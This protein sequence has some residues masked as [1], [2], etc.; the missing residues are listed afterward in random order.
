MLV[1]VEPPPYESPGSRKSVSK[2]P[3]PPRAPLEQHNALFNPRRQNI[4]S[5]ADIGVTLPQQATELAAIPHER[6]KQAF[7]LSPACLA[8]EG[9]DPAALVIRRHIAVARSRR[10]ASSIDH[11]CPDCADGVEQ[12]HREKRETGKKAREKE[13]KRRRRDNGLDASS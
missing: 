10:A 4:P 6:L 13:E 11:G 8:G 5:S 2:C 12:R 1:R 9:H 7:G 3:S